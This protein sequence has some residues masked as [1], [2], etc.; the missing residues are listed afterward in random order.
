MQDY[1]LVM[2]LSPD[3]DEE[4]ASGVVSKVT[5]LITDRGGALVKQDNWGLRRLAYPIQKYRE[6]NYILAQFSLDPKH[7]LELE[8]SLRVAPAVIRH[9]LVLRG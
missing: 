8:S 3:M 2:V 1:E 4:T 9:L 6:G 7:T 5:Q